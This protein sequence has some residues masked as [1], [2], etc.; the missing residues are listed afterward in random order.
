MRAAL[1]A[2]TMDDPSRSALQE[3]FE[4]S[5]RYLENSNPESGFEHAELQQGCGISGEIGRCWL[6]QLE[7]DNVVAAIGRGELE[8]VKRLL[9]SP[10]LE[11]HLSQSP[12]VLAAIFALMIRSRDD[13]LVCHVAAELAKYPE[14]ATERQNGRT[15]LHDAAAAG[16]PSIVDLLVGICAD[17]NAGD[18]GGHGPLYSV[19]N[20]CQWPE[21]APIVRLLLRAGAHVDN[22]SGEMRCSALH[23]AARRGNVKVAEAL[24]EGGASIDIRDVRGDTPLR[25]AVN[26]RKAEVAR[27]LVDRGADIR[28]P[29]SKGLTPLSAAKTEAIRGALLR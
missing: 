23:A 29:G 8:T 26:C 12:A 14:T 28:S 4:V 22:R 16:V 18:G 10:I 6:A 17:P 19:A 2:T 20:E 27:L 9:D 13:A 1:D 11:G 7:L 3:L 21:G 15:L 5:S 25:R 24:I